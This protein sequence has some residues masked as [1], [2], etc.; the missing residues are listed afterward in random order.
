MEPSEAKSS[1]PIELPSGLVPKPSFLA[2]SSLTAVRSGDAR[3][4]GLSEASQVRRLRACTGGGGCGR[5]C[6]GRHGGD[7]A[8]GGLAASARRAGAAISDGWVAPENDG[9]SGR[10][11]IERGDIEEKLGGSGG[12]RAAASGATA[13]ASKAVEIEAMGGFGFEGSVVEDERALIAG[14]AG[15][16]IAPAEQP[17]G[18]G[19]EEFLKLFAAG[20]RGRDGGGDRLRREPAACANA[21]PFPRRGSPRTAD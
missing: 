13:S 8:A 19:G 2:V 10:A 12:G 16:D 5:R 20:T 11:G 18:P 21:R 7:L 3:A 1:G 6:R 4:G 17:T 9:L 15:G 14:A